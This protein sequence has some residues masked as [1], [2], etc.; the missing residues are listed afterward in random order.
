VGLPLVL[1]L[2]HPLQRQI[3]KVVEHSK[4]KIGKLHVIEKKIHRRNETSEKR[5]VKYPKIL[6]IKMF[7]RRVG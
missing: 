4:I 5:N 7:H 3:N 1:D 6:S 2:L